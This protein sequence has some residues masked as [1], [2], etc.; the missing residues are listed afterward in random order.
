MRSAFANFLLQGRQ[1][2]A[3]H[4]VVVGQPG[5]GQLGQVLA[6]DLLQ[7]ELHAQQGQQVLA[8]VG[9]VGLLH[10]PGLVL[11]GGRVGL[12]VGVQGAGQLAVGLTHGLA[13]LLGRIGLPLL[14]RARLGRRLGLGSVGSARGVFGL[15]AGQA[16]GGVSH[17]FFHRF[18]PVALDHLFAQDVAKHHLG[19]GQ[20]DLLLVGQADVAVA[21]EY[22]LGFG[23][24]TVFQH[25]G[26]Q[27]R[28][29]GAQ[30][31]AL[32]F[33]QPGFG[34]LVGEQVVKQ[35]QQLEA[36]GRELRLGGLQ[37]G[38]QALMKPQ[39]VLLPQ[40]QQIAQLLDLADQLVEKPLGLGL[41]RCRGRDGQQ[42]RAGR[43]CR[44]GQIVEQ[45][46]LGLSRRL[47]GVPL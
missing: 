47:V 4:A 45:G 41:R 2:L 26:R 39:F 40:R 8:F 21:V 38:G 16:L 44:A 43:R 33:G 46:G 7:I 15:G 18:G 11:A 14:R 5:F 31:A 29:P 12:T 37:L 24:R 28:Y 30:L 3:Q 1:L 23:V 36:H 25:R 35:A 13:G 9:L 19:L 27:L 20:L 17:Q 42:R 34:I 32:G 10:Q 6:V 22:R